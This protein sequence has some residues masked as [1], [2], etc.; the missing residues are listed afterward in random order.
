[1][2]RLIQRFVPE[3]AVGELTESGY[4]MALA[5]LLARHGV[6]TPEQA[7]AFLNPSAEQLRDPFVLTGMLRATE[8][9]GQAVNAGERLTVFGDYDVDGICAAALLSEALIRHGA[10]VSV[11]IPE[12]HGEGYGLTIPALERLRLDCD[13]LITV[14]CG[15]TAVDEAQWARANGLRM[16]ITDHHEP[17]D[18]LPCCEAL[19]DPAIDTPKGSP[20]CGAGVAFKLVQ[21]LY[22]WSEASRALDLAAL[23]TVADLVPLL[24]ENRV[25]V[26]LGLEAIRRT[27]RVGLRALI[28]AAG[29]KGKPLN[30]GYV[31]FQLAPRLNSAGRIGSA[32]RGIDLLLTRDQDEAREIADELNANNERRQTIQR[33]LTKEAEKRVLEI[34]DFRRDRLIAPDGFGWNT[35]V[36]GLAASTLTDKYHLPAIVFSVDEKDGAL[37]AV[38]S[39]RSIPGV[40]IQRAMFTC[41]DLFTR[42]GGHAQAAGCTLPAER[43]P[44]L[45]ERLNRAIIEQAEPETFIPSERYDAVIAL[46]DI[47]IQFIETLKRLEPHGIGNP[48]PTFLINDARTAGAKKVGSDRRHLKLRLFQDEVGVDGIAFGQAEQYD[49]SLGDLPDRMDALVHCSI[50]EYMGAR[51]VQFIGQR[52]LPSSPLDAFEQRCQAMRGRF[53]RALAGMIMEPPQSVPDVYPLTQAELRGLVSDAIRADHQGVLLVSRTLA[54][55]LDWIEWLR[56]SGLANRIDCVTTAPSDPRAFHTLAA[57]PSLTELSVRYDRV[58]F[59]DLPPNSGELEIIRNA[60]PGALIWLDEDAQDWEADAAALAPSEDTL[61]A[62]YRAL[63]NPGVRSLSADTYALMFGVPTASI[64]LGLNVFAQ[65]GLIEWIEEPFSCIILSQANQ[66]AGQAKRSLDESALYRRMKQLRARYDLDNPASIAAGGHT[67]VEVSL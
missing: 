43:L 22:G 33:T 31:G 23:A 28:G 62:L 11:H 42:F 14:D 36:I 17:L 3:A 61:R 10:N 64:C 37:I 40:H 63:R 66:S 7:H 16:V 56:R 38:G 6:E 45:R 35:G 12:R 19:V 21:A 24:G 51:A 26:A 54:A 2:L 20:L 15:I 53:E 5:R 13:L 55:A 4:P 29:L 60:C 50:N 27:E 30:A 58:A 49:D 18:T 46:R 44:E 52:L 67:A 25:I 9:I 39:A 41:R 59:L 47:T 32:A 8:V 48:T 34:T 1:M 65:L 57:L